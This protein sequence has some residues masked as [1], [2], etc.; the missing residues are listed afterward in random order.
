MENSKLLTLPG[1]V[2]RPLGSPVHS[3]PLYRL[4]YR[5]SWI[6]I[7]THRIYTTV[8][9]GLTYIHFVLSRW[10]EKWRIK[11]NG[12]KSVHVT[13]HTRREMCSLPPGPY[14][15][16][17]TPARKRCQVSPATPWQETYLAQ[18]QFRKTET[19]RNHRHQNV[20][21]TRTQVKTL[22]KQQTTHI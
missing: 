3:Q 5:D 16:C 21:V 15:Q 7:G 14:K 18:I 6:I 19:T 1:L 8:E 10:F 11:A 17:A 22:Y 9:Q 13:F 20:L 12:S 2:L 4:R